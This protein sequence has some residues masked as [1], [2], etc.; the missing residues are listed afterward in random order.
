MYREYA[1]PVVPCGGI[2]AFL[3]ALGAICLKS[4]SS[5]YIGDTTLFGA[6]GIM[7]AALASLPMGFILG[8][9]FAVTVNT[10][11]LMSAPLERAKPALGDGY[12]ISGYGY[13]PRSMLLFRVWGRWMVL[14]SVGWS[15]GVIALGVFSVFIGQKV[16][17]PEGAF[18][19]E[20]NLVVGLW[21]GLAVSLAQKV[22]V[23]Q[24]MSVSL[25]WVWVA[26]I[27]IGSPFALIGALHA[28]DMWLIP[29]VAAGGALFGFLQIR[30]MRLRVSRTYW[31]IF[32][33]MVS[34]SA[35]WFF[36]YKGLLSGLI[37]SPVILGGVTGLGFIALRKS[38]GLTNA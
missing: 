1:Y 15:S 37:L 31:W 20:V 23:R 22:A 34:W 38:P 19:F 14:S 16:P 30:S 18:P 10:G 35:A 27:A 6:F 12:M 5:T 29:G 7:G 36:L 28:P 24:W 4:T 25:R 26:A 32:V 2:G 8:V 11:F 13:M 17:G 21:M 9:L 3:T 33:N